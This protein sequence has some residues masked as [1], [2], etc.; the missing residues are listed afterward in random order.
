M[1]MLGQQ[2]HAIVLHGAFQETPVQRMLGEVGMRRRFIRPYLQQSDIL[3]VRPGR[4]AIATASAQ[5]PVEPQARNGIQGRR[6]HAHLLECPK[7][8]S[9]RTKT[10]K[11]EGNERAVNGH[12]E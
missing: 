8:V 5:Q 2:V 4:K 10:E 7:T 3:G 11:A 12:A 9:P 1:T 6:G